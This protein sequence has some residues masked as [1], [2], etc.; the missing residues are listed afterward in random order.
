MLQVFLAVTLS[1]LV[2]RDGT[3]VICNQLQYRNAS[4]DGKLLLSVTFL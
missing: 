4:Y 3:C 2:I 1:E